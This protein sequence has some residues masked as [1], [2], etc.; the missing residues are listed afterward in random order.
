MV[1]ELIL[2]CGKILLYLLTLPGLNSTHPTSE[3]LHFAMED[4]RPSTD[5]ELSQ[6]KMDLKQYSVN[7]KKAQG[8]RQNYKIEVHDYS[9]EKVAP[10]KSKVTEPQPGE[11]YQPLIKRKEP[12]AMTQGSAND[13]ANIGVWVRYLDES[14][15]LTYLYNEATGESKWES[16]PDRNS[17]AVEQQQGT[18]VQTFDDDG[19]AY[20]YN[21]VSH[22]HWNE[23]ANTNF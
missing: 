23:E 18:W 14:S 6:Y 10:K 4:R 20:F 2:S 13:Q 8:A 16:E 21:Q 22:V 1:C 12:S 11:N 17:E 19:N 9:V 3:K 15:G 5:S 7:P